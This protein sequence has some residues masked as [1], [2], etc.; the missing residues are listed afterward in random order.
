[1]NL[2]IRRGGSIDGDNDC[3]EAGCDSLGSV[4]SDTLAAYSLG[5]TTAHMEISRNDRTP[6]NIMIAIMPLLQDP[7]SIE[8]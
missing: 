3:R 8:C 4:L 7:G 2:S 6:L 5:S 1:M